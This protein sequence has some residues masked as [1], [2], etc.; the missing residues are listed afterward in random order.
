MLHKDESIIQESMCS[1]VSVRTSAKLQ[2][3]SVKVIREYKYYYVQNL[4]EYFQMETRWNIR[5]NLIETLTTIASIDSTVVSL[6]L[7]SVLPLE[8][9]QTMYE[10]PDSIARLKHL[11]ILLTIIFSQGLRMCLFTTWSNS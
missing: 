9:V 1:L 4:V 2:V 5:R 6:M 7:N 10:N 8:L 3:S 11:A